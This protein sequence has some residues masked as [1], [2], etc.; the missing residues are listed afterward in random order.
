MLE[1]RDG[2]RW[3]YRGSGLSD[4][5]R[6]HARAGSS[7]T[8]SSAWSW[9]L[10]TH[11]TGPDALP[12]RPHRRTRRDRCTPRSGGHHPG[13]SAA[14][15]RSHDHRLPRH[16]DRER[17]RDG[18]CRRHRPAGPR[19]RSSAAGQGLYGLAMG[20]SNSHEMS[21]ASSSRPTSSRPGPTPRCG[22]STVPSW[23]SPHRWPASWPTPGGSGPPFSSPPPSSRSWRSGSRSRPSAPCARPYEENLGRHGTSQVRLSRA[24][25]RCAHVVCG[26][27]R[28]S[29][30]GIAMSSGV[31]GGVDHVVLERGEVAST[32]RN[33]R[34][35]ASG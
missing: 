31:P 27:R 29:G 9:R 2:V 6:R 15:N 5:G 12:V 8:R 33:Q 35:T 30:R 16:L 19:S 32:W 21:F 3:V 1:I 14:R 13:G 28:R 34:G 18:G 25:W 17:A 20:M 7:A 26:G 4:P 23:S 10:R 22:L 24:G 11:R